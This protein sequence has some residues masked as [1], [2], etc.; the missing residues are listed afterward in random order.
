MKEIYITSGAMEGIATA[1]MT[2]VNAGD[3]VILLAPC[4]SSHIEQVH[5]AG[6]TPVF[7]HLIENEGWRLDPERVR[8]KVTKRTKAIL[9]VQ[10]GNPHG[11]LFGEEEL[12]AVGEI[13]REN[14][15]MI[16][17]DDPYSWLVYDKNDKYFS[18]WMVPELKHNVISCHSFSKEFAMSGFRV[19]FVYTE[20]SILNH[21]LKIH[22][23]FTVCASHPSQIAA[24]AALEGPKDCV[25][26]F[27]EEY[28]ARRALIGV[29][30]DQLSGLFHY[31]PCQGAYYIFAAIVP[32]ISSY[33]LAMK[34]LKETH[35]IMVPGAAFGEGGEGHMR[36]SFTSPRDEIKEGMERVLKWWGVTELNP[37]NGQPKGSKA[38]SPGRRSQEK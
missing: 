38:G 26:E 36:L 13:C 17:C 32:D 9:I 8:Q 16:M 37:A 12:R 1:I 15:I 23:A 18:L 28:R 27:V 20:A 25:S 22:D 11:G 7:V 24:I 29:Y 4:F 19:G 35:V 2:L 34:I 21:M 5:L 31:Q 30:L 14:N 3:E 6:G 33:E 10:P